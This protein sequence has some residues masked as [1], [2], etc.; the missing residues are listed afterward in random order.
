MTG[1][2]VCAMTSLIIA[3]SDERA[4]PPSRL[5]SAGMRSSAITATAPASSAMRACS[6]ST[7]SMITPP[8]WNTAKARLTAVSTSESGTGLGAHGA[9]AAASG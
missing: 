8:F 3:G 2:V 1:S 5:M 9:V 7:T 6:P 4:T